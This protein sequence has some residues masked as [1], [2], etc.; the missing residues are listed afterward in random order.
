[1]SEQPVRLTFRNGGWV[2]LMTGIVLAGIMV[3]AIA[4]AALRLT[5][6]PPGDNQTIESYAF[7]LSNLQIDRELV[8]PAMRHRN[9]SPV[10]TDPKILS[11]EEIVQRNN[12]IRDPLVVSKDLVVGVEIGGESRAYPLH[13]LHVHEI[14]ND[15]LGGTPIAIVWHWPSGHLAVFER[16]IDSNVVS[17][18][19]S[20]LSGNGGMLFYPLQEKIGNERLFASMLE[21]SVTGEDITLTPVPHDVVSWKNWFAEHPDTTS[22]APNEQLK[23]RYRKASPELY[24]LT[25]VIYFPTSPMP[26]D[27]ANPKTPVIA[28]SIDGVER[29]YAIP[30]LLK[31]A[32]DN[33]RVTDLFGNNTLI[34]TIEENPITASIRTKDGQRVHTNRSL[35]FA[36]HA[37]HPDSV[38]EIN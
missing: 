3:W 14:V 33:G 37:N 26:Q 25:E 32:D 36:W 5:S 16:T 8:V 2:L 38:L 35:W 28:V 10:V 22:L 15:T 19:N 21:K 7:D 29:V 30:S 20:G 31:L 12:S 13:F 24:F 18:A 11:P 17:F 6:M 9:M 27:E 1:M 23:K 4:P 34:F